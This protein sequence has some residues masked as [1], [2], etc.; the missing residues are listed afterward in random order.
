MSLQGLIPQKKYVESN[1]IQSILSML[2]IGKLWS[3]MQS[4][5]FTTF[6][7]VVAKELEYIEDHITYLFTESVTGTSTDTLEDWE[8]NVGL[9]E[10]GTLLA[11]TIEERR[12]QAHAKIYAN[13]NQG[14]N[15]Q[16]Y[17]DYAA[18][19]GFI[20]KFAQESNSTPFRVG[21]GRMGDRIGGL[22]SSGSGV[23]GVV[24]VKVVGG[25][26][27]TDYLQDV[28]EILKP[29]HV[30]LLWE[31]LIYNRN[32]VFSFTD[33]EF[34]PVG[35]GNLTNEVA[36]DSEAYAEDH[37]NLFAQYGFKELVSFW[38]DDLE[39]KRPTNVSYTKGPS[40]LLAS[41]GDFSYDWAFYS[42]MT[43]SGSIIARRLDNDAEYSMAI[44]FPAAASVFT[45]PH[46]IMTAAFDMGGSP[47]V[48]YEQ[49]VD[50]IMVWRVIE[51]SYTFDGYSPLLVC[52]QYYVPE[53]NPDNVLFDT[54]CLYLKDTTGYSG[55]WNY[56]ELTSI[57]DQLEYDTRAGTT[58][59]ARF[60]RNNFEIEYT[61][62][63][64]D[65]DIAYIENAWF[66]GDPDT[67]NPA[68]DFGK[69]YVLYISV[70][71]TNKVRHTLKSANYFYT[72][73]YPMDCGVDETSITAE[74]ESGELF[75][76]I[77]F[78][79]DQTEGVGITAAISD[80]VLLNM[81]AKYDG[82]GSPEQIG[83]TAAIASGV[84]FDLTVSA[85]MQT[86][87]ASLTAAISS[88][89][90]TSIVITDSQHT[91][92]TSMTAEIASG[93]LETV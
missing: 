17:I 56:D 2:P 61:L 46:G 16:F 81:E 18:V 43:A 14:L 93:L 66:D 39:S 37:E 52:N 59:Y 73:A 48:G 33:Y 36:S 60:Q 9:P 11:S 72:N 53:A 38:D 77:A 92:T 8:Y 15:A 27:G 55:E 86:D 29:A 82:T 23:A 68:T 67:Y 34:A 64:S 5:Q 65:F 30:L 25:L 83:I 57:I 87:A 50:T 32:I 49:D 19:L 63:T 44:A 21:V 13:Y 85:T 76:T 28:F 78:A 88:G 71:D 6:L 45:G 26:E 69:E 62:C 7:S 42:P 31:A 35:I 89:S 80:G 58:I 47:V 24:V 41:E 4:N 54:I 79:P 91:E 10:P 1:Y 20:I 40:V 22:T 74:V 70:R 75:E 90:N 84:L 51:G 12:T 3:N